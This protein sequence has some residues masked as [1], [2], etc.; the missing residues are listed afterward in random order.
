M[1]MSEFHII[2]FRML[3]LLMNAESKRIW[4]EEIA[5]QSRNVQELTRKMG[6]ES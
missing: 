4:E 2:Q 6:Q 5:M 1:I 3:G